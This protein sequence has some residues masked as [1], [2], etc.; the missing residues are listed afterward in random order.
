MRHLKSAQPAEPSAADLLDA[1]V[2]AMKK[3]KKS[4]NPR[5]SFDKAIAEVT[6]MRE[7]KNWK[8]AKGRHL[9]ALYVWLHTEIYGVEPAELLVKTAYIRACG[10]A[11]RLL[12]DDF[13]GDCERVVGFLSWVWAKERTKTKA[14]KQDSFR[15]GWR[16]QF[17]TKTLLTNYRVE[18]VRGLTR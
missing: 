13:G 8:G 12:K 6:A 5:A 18:L 14:G 11:E 9:V 7:S 4:C 2:G 17:A 10:A 16:Y 15:I 1:E 3:R